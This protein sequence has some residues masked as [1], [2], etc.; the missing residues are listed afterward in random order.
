[1]SVLLIYYHFLQTPTVFT[2]YNTTDVKFVK[3]LKYT[4]LYNSLNVYVKRNN[5][6]SESS[7]NWKEHNFI[8]KKSISLLEKSKKSHCLKFGE[9]WD[10]YSASNLWWKK[11]KK[12]EP[13][14]SLPLNITRADRNSHAHY[15]EELQLANQVTFLNREKKFKA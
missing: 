13:I 5:L 1:M 14:I 3:K 8:G 12:E 7:W 6:P 10:K 9:I 11:S 2:L 4:I 15:F